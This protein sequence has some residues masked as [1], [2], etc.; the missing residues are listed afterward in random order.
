MFLEQFL[1]EFDDS[2]AG[3]TY[4]D[5]LGMLVIW[6]AFGQRIFKNRVNSISNDVRNYTLN[7]FNH[8]LIRRLVQDDAVVLER[9]MSSLYG[10]K[11]SLQFKYAC[12]I[13]LE[14]LFVYSM[15]EQEGSKD[16]D[17]RGVLGITKARRI[18]EDM[19]HNPQMVFSHEKRS[20]ILVRQLSLGVSG[21]YKTSFME[22]GYFDSGY[23]YQLP[24]AA[25]H[26]AETERFIA[27]TP[28]LLKLSEGIFQHLKILLAQ[29]KAHP[30]T[31]FASVLAD[32][33]PK[34]YAVAFASPG[35][36]GLYARDYWLTSTGLNRG[37]A[38]ALL[39]VLDD[40]SSRKSTRD[41][42]DK[43]LI[44]KALKISLASDEHTKMQHIDWLEPFLADASLLFT[45]LVSKKTQS[46]KEVVK[47][48][49]QYSRDENTLPLGAQRVIAHPDLLQ[50][51]SGMA[52][53][54]LQTLLELHKT[55]M[56]SEQIRLLV[57]YHNAVME[58]RRQ[59][60]WLNV[61]EHGVIKVHT[62]TLRTPKTEDWPIG[63]WTNGY[64]LPQFKSLVLGYQGGPV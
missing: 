17:S 47:L 54:R 59:S 3:E 29:N 37:A 18:W 6:S 16:V 61:D 52:R 51:L 14:N 35:A 2:L 64:Y 31:T 44:A 13:Y 15:L 21:R 25:V 45:L 22:I 63:C 10:G 5:P 55:T 36:V 12:L 26:W 58:G 56:L 39:Q 24:S 7:L 48:W 27:A 53:K 41:F 50:V 57:G 32:K 9:V 43:Q 46:I 42:D 8:Y 60:A 1:T 11:D 30:H 28:V 62:R 4:I 49:R 40:N 38:G 33:L 20:H 19:Q 23:H 34:L